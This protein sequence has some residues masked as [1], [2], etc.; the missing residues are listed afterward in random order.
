MFATRLQNK[1]YSL[2]ELCVNL[3]VIIAIAYKPE[4]LVSVTTLQEASLCKSYQK[5]KAVIPSEDED[6]FDKD[7]VHSD[8]KEW[9][10]SNDEEWLGPDNA[11]IG[12]VLITPHA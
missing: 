9:L 10:P 2:F 8:D 3:L 11:E 1:S 12:M 4:F 7:L 5:S 6:S